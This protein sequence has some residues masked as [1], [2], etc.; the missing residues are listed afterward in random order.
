MKKDRRETESRNPK[1]S[2][3]KH[4]AREIFN[5][6]NNLVHK[7]C[8]L[9]I[10]RIHPSFFRRLRSGIFNKTDYYKKLQME[11]ICALTYRAIAPLWVTRIP[12]GSV[13]TG[14]DPS[15][16]SGE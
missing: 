12:E 1:H 10:T 3:E 7:E 2:N 5:R 8:G 13:S 6:R 4:L 9:V 15:G 14:S 16:T 11:K